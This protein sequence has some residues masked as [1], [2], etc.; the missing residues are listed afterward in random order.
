MY[1]K[2]ILG[3]DESEDSM[4]AAE[5]VMVLQKENDAKV[6]IFNSVLH[7]I[8]DLRPAFGTSPVPD[9]YLQ[10]E[11]D[12][13]RANAATVLLDELKNKYKAEGLEVETRIIYDFGPQYYIE[14]QVKEENFDL[15]VLGCKGEHSKLR[16]TIVG[17]VP[18]YVI[19]HVD[20]DVLIAK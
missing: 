16:R 20:V 15:V 10:Y 18:E 14:K 13:D 4:K 12:R 9:G 7:H 11:V 1:K 8:S 17:T 3:V 6:V 5:K 19:N 2:I